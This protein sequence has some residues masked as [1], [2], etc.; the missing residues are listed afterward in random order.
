[1]TGSH[2]IQCGGFQWDIH[3]YPHQGP[4]GNTFAVSVHPFC[5]RLDDPLPSNYELEYSV[6]TRVLPS[7]TE[8]SRPSR[9]IQHQWTKRTNSVSER[10]SVA[11]SGSDD[12][13]KG[14]ESS[15]IEIL[16]FSRDDV[17]GTIFDEED[18]HFYLEIS[19]KTKFFPRSR[20]SVICAPYHG[21][22]NP[23][24][25][26]SGVF[27]AILLQ[28][29]KRLKEVEQENERLKQKNHDLE[30]QMIGSNR[31]QK[32]F[33][34]LHTAALVRVECQLK[35]LG[36]REDEIRRLRESNDYLMEQIND[37]SVS[38]GTR[39][40][41]SE[42]TSSLNGVNPPRDQQSVQV[43]APGSVSANFTGSQQP[44]IWKFPKVKIT[45]DV[46]PVNDDLEFQHR[47]V[48]AWR[49]DAEQNKWRGRG[50]GLVQLYWNKLAQLGVLRFTDEKHN[51]IR[52]LQWINGEG[53]CEYCADVTAFDSNNGGTKLNKEEL[54]WFGA[55]YTMDQQNPMIGKWK[56]H[57]MENEDAASH[58]M[59]VFNEH[60]GAIQRGQNDDSGTFETLSERQEQSHVDN[61]FTFQVDAGFGNNFSVNE[62][63]KT[64]G[65]GHQNGSDEKEDTVNE[66]SIS[67]TNTNDE[68]NMLE[69]TFKPIVQ[70]EEQH[71][72]TG[73]ENETLIAECHY[74]KLYRF[75]PDVS[76][77]MGWKNRGSHSTVCFYKDN[78]TGAV[79]M[80]SREHI[81]NKLRMN[82]MVYPEDKASFT[83]KT[84]KMYS[85][86]A[87][88]ATIATEEGN[89]NKGQSAW[90]IKFQSE[91]L[92]VEFA[93]HFQ[94]A[95]MLNAEMDVIPQHNDCDEN[96]T[97]DAKDERLQFVFQPDVSSDSPFVDVGASPFVWVPD[98][99]EE[100]QRHDKGGIDSEGNSVQ[101]CSKVGR[102][103]D[104]SESK[105]QPGVGGGLSSEAVAKWDEGIWG[106]DSVGQGGG[107]ESFVFNMLVQH[108]NQQH[109]D[110]YQINFN[111]ESS[112]TLGH[113]VNTD[114][115]Q[116]EQTETKKDSE[117]N[118]S[119]ADDE[120]NMVECTFKPIVQLEEV[121]VAAGTEGDNQLGSFEIVKLYRWG[122]D[123]DGFAGWKN[124]ASNTRIDFWQQPNN[125]KVRVICRE[126]VTSKLRMNHWIPQS[127]LANA[128]LR[129]E[130]FVQW[131]GFDTTVHAEDKDDKNGFCMFNCKFRDGE[132]AKKFYDLLLESIDNNQ[133]FIGNRSEA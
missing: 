63:G 43:E 51:K 54:E 85:W 3:L 27:G 108:S 9:L 130:K 10:F 115:V 60:L 123:V 25:Q 128:Q 94:N 75:G 129:A 74:T 89:V 83:K 118:G 67:F 18:D 104:D 21:M 44:D 58:F 126:S 99:E 8:R 50:K 69:C 56:M 125:G 12:D 11:R 57:F 70:L 38:V 41:D 40:R 72:A 124:R 22:T 81:T 62:W 33:D 52:L 46:D 112:D 29:E 131:S 96:D 4:D 95:M 55:D 19:I 114:A 100:K 116:S 127:S 84:P 53:P 105:N 93:E 20:S 49:Y 110:C 31:A 111:T 6:T 15:D 79:R 119:N 132:T 59:S 26:Y 117:Q 122:K 73:H 120:D 47:P 90:L 71:V 7:F 17:F 121:N 101:N 102:L 39:E 88:D 23:R 16:P 61:P 133:K 103:D 24:P 68:D 66:E 48:R 1:M 113:I 80:I 42:S 2:G 64:F 37:V 107:L 13:V 106:T 30:Q 28:T 97:T 87:F 98:S 78:S 35:R 92:A 34:T 65:G 86:T 45:L 91:K 76:G 14:D 77:D 82:Q 36:D 32:Q 5:E 109:Q